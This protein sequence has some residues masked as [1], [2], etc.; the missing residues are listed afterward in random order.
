MKGVANSKHAFW[1]ALVIT[2]AIFVIGL[3]LGVAIEG[4]RATQAAESYVISELSLMDSFA[5]GKITQ[6]SDSIEC[7]VLVD[8]NVEFA[9][10]IYSEA[11]AVEDYGDS[12][13]LTEEVKLVLKRYDLLRT[14]LWINTMNLP[15]ECAV[16]TSVVVYL[17][18]R[19]TEDLVVESKNKVW[20]RVLFD[21]KKELGNE[22]ILI[23][24][25]AANSEFISLKI[26]LSDLEVDAYP[27][28]IIDNEHVIFEVKTVEEL[29]EYIN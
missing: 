11:Q 25:S 10:K 23:P 20:E 24:I 27:A 15:E 13:K 16:E 7:D 5:L 19:D 17:F 29:K 12:E 22:I 1:Q 9:D 4:K 18:D 2:I 8:A 28:V 3:F 26:L 14:L 21:L 6:D